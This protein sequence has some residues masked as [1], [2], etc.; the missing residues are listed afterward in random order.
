MRSF[1]RFAKG[2]LTTGLLAASVIGLGSCGSYSIYKIDISSGTSTG[3]SDIDECIMT[4]TDEND[5]PVVSNLRLAPVYGAPDSSG[6]PTLLQ[7]CSS[8]ITNQK[9]GTF[10]Y[11]TSR[12]SGSLKFQVDGFSNKNGEHKVVQ[13]G[14]TDAIPVKAYPPEIGIAITIK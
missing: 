10:S 13:T 11:S 8:Q 3:R 4:I 12:S 7:G 5:K 6:Q 1:T 14:K 9:I 2:L